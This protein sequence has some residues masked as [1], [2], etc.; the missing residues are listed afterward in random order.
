MRHCVICVQCN[1]LHSSSVYAVMAHNDRLV[2]ERAEVQKPEMS[3][4]ATLAIVAGILIIIG[5]LSGFA[6]MS[7]WQGMYGA[8]DGMMGGGSMLMRGYFES[9]IIAL[10]SIGLAAGTLV[11]IGGLKVGSES[12]SNG[13]WSILILV[14]SIV[15]L[16]GIG[17]FGLGAVLGIVAGAI[18][19]SRIAKT[20]TLP[21]H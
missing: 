9:S 2:M 21:Y 3:F 19:I 1:A 14:G 5:G 13:M 8:M 11:L 7:W 4:P 15:A 12:S 6:L 16:F 18:A 17:G 20:Q 10:A